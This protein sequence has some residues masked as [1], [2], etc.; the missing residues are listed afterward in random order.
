[1][2]IPLDRAAAAADRK[3]SQPA[4]QVDAGRQ[5]AKLLGLDKLTPPLTFGAAQVIGDGASAAAYMEVSDGS[6]IRFASLR[7]MAQVN[8]LMAEVVA[9]TGA[10]PKINQQ[11]AM[12]AVAL[13]KQH[14]EHVRSMSEEDEAIDWGITFLTAADVLDLDLDDQTQRWGAFTRL[15]EIDPRETSRQSGISIAAASTVL[16]AEDGTR[17]VRTDWM[18]AWVKSIEP[19]MTPAAIAALMQRVG[20]IRRGTKGRWKA[21]RPGLP[22]Q[23]NM[24]FWVVPPGWDDRGEEP[25]PRNHETPANEPAVT[26]GAQESPAG[27]RPHTRAGGVTRGHRAEGDSNGGEAEPRRHVD[28]TPYGAAPAWMPERGGRS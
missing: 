15:G 13:L 8:R 18:R 2:S 3:R 9:T 11:G 6:V 26:P 10:L 23:Q 12:Q 28:G 24:A 17:L 27:G 25:P 7:D 5:L 16:R 19:R 20:W 14:A 22:G 1:M 21:T 4:G